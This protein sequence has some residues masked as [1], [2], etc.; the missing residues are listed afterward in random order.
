MKRGN[1][2]TPNKKM[3]GLVWTLAGVL[4][5]LLIAMF[6]LAVFSKPAERLQEPESS[7][8]D[9]PAT[10]PVNPTEPAAVPEESE[11]ET[12][13]EETAED[14]EPTEPTEPE[15]RTFSVEWMEE[16]DRIYVTSQYGTLAYSAAFSD[17]VQVRGVYDEDVAVL[18]FEGLIGD[19]AVELFDIRYGET[20]GE[21]LRQVQTESGETVDAYLTIHDQPQGLSEDDLNTFYAA[22]EILNEVMASLMES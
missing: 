11:E 16:D 3:R 13:P 6:C 21:L 7:V 18:K 22:Q 19:A 20:E 2:E 14:T 10:E 4:L 5:A 9:G 8:A 17:V 12:V 15:V 1:F